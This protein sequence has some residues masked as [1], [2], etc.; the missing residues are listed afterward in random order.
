MK[1]RSGAGA[2]GGSG[3]RRAAAGPDVPLAGSTLAEL[4]RR[5][6]EAS[7]PGRRA[8]PE[9]CVGKTNTLSGGVKG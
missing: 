7:I 9:K 4:V 2:A 1:G 5:R 8:S 6:A 3:G